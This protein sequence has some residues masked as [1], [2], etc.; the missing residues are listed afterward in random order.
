MRDDLVIIG[1]PEQ[2]SQDA[3]KLDK[4]TTQ[5]SKCYSKL[6]H[7]SPCASYGTKKKHHNGQKPRPIVAKLEHY[8]Q[9]QQV[10]KQ[11]SQLKGTNYGMNDRSIVCQG[12][13]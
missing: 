4:D 11:G 10:Q 6:H 8:K 5:T 13:G 1:I 3:E 12:L 2:P 7:I 9:K